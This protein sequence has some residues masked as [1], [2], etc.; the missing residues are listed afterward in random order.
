MVEKSATAVQ[1]A[2]SKPPVKSGK[3][4]SLTERVN[5]LYDDISRRAFELFERDGRADGNDV[6]HWLEAE[7][8]FLHPTHVRLEESEGEFTVFAE[9]PGFNASDLEVNV[10][11]RRVT[12]SGKRESKHESKQ[13][14][15]VYSEKCSNE[16]FRTMDLPSDANPAKVTATLKDGILEIQIPK[17]EAKKA[18]AAEP[19][20]SQA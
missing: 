16:I 4:E 8:D 19:P 17:A 18:A 9:V 7:K 10:E 5:R 6:R 3:T 13:G 20:V 2:P 15:A 11:P 14:E 1:T 12:L